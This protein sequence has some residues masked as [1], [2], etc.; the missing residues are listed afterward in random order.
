MATNFNKGVA[1]N[2]VYG[3]KKGIKPT[4][5]EQICYYCGNAI[6]RG[7][8]II[9]VISGAFYAAPKYTHYHHDCFRKGIVKYLK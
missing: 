5:H 4:A 2:E 6:Y 7:D 8:V 9:S 3:I 1:N